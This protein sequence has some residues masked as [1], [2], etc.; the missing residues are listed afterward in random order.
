MN[1]SLILFDSVV[2][3]RW[4][5]RTSIVLFLNKVDLFRAKIERSPLSNYFPEYSGGND[6]N[7]AAKFLLWKFT[8]VNRAHLTL[9]PQYVNGPLDHNN[10]KLHTDNYSPSP[11]FSQLDTSYRHIKH[12]ARLLR[13]QGDYPTKCLARLGYSVITIIPKLDLRLQT[14]ENTPSPSPSRT[15]GIQR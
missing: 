2:N 9:Y 10:W 15:N 12:Q 11:F 7:R 1:E 4:F 8:Q 5:M 6:P 14:W 3:S 13:R